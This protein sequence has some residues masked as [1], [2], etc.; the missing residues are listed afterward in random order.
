MNL[1][2]YSES[3]KLSPDSNKPW[4]IIIFREYKTKFH[5]EKKLLWKNGSSNGI[6]LVIFQ[7][8][9]HRIMAILIAA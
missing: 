3:D 5:A 7:T 6:V 9:K 8:N 1:S 2:N 4:F